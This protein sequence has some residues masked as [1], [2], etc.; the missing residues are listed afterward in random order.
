MAYHESLDLRDDNAASLRSTSSN[1]EVWCRIEISEQMILLV[2][3][4]G[5]D[6]YSLQE[7]VIMVFSERVPAGEDM[8]GDELEWEMVACVSDVSTA[9]TIISWIWGEDMDID[10]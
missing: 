4:R 5:N 8:D 6:G 1:E 9:M 7:E 2:R 3:D 10:S